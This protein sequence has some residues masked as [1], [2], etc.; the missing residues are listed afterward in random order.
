MDHNRDRCDQS[1]WREVLD[2]VVAGIGRGTRAR[3]YHEDCVAVGRRF[4]PCANPDHRTGTSSVLNYDLLAKRRCEFSGDHSA[5]CVNAAT[6]RERDDQRDR[7]DGIVLGHRGCAAGERKKHYTKKFGFVIQ[8]KH[9]N[10]PL[11]VIRVPS[12]L[13]IKTENRGL[14]NG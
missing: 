5:N 4:R 13:A 11:R 10:L 6:G 14:Q 1:D 2:Y 7:T 8:S 3:G 12:T 9:G